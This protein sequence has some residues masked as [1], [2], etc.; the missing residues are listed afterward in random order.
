MF[1]KISYGV[2]LALVVLFVGAMVF[3]S[4]DTEPV[5]TSSEAKKV[6]EV[7]TQSEETKDAP[8]NETFTEGDV[9]ELD[10]MQYTLKNAKFS[11]P[12][13]Y[14]EP[15]KGKIITLELEAKNVK[16][17]EGSVSS[18]DFN[19]SGGD[20]QT[21]DEYFFLMMIQALTVNFVKVRR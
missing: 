13:E 1:K 15:E 10:G 9:V 20:G 3:G 8:K 11:A 19:V 2:I 12:A 17:S 21:F 18:I 4:D 6:D 14:G 16:A 5:D 7:S